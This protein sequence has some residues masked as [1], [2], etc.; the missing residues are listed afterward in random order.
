MHTRHE[1]S[2]HE[3]NGPTHHPKKQSTHEP[4]MKCRSKF[5]D[6]NYK[7]SG[8]LKNKVAIVTG[9]ASGI[10]KAASILFAIEGAHVV[11][12]YLDEH[13]EASET[14][15]IIESYGKHCILMS[16]EVHDPFF[17]EKIIEKT[18]HAFN[19]INILVNNSAEQ[20]RAQH[21]E[22]I[23]FDQFEKTFRT[24][25]FS[26]FYMTKFVLPHLKKGDTIINTTSVSAY[27]GNHHLIDYSSTKGAIVSFTRSLSENLIKQGI[28]VNAVA[29]G[30]ITPPS[31]PSIFSSL[32]RNNEKCSHDVPMGRPGEPKEIA[33]CYVFLASE[34]SS[35][36][37][38]QV[39]HPN[40]GVIVN[41]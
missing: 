14:K 11:I 13:D 4:K 15:E 30:S 25:V 28:R 40:G 39:L 26:Y 21:F 23:T 9:G 2:D 5:L 19:V 1:K 22:D 34:D 10:G 8:K 36:M 3:K 31:T 20:Y 27:K 37:S 35:Y 6:T 18:L 24:N 33:P 29:P 7:G 16:G 12:A 38:G 17:C 41:G 32:S